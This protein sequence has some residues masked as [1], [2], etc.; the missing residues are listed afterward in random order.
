MVLYG[1]KIKTKDFSE[2]VAVYDIK[3]GKMKSTK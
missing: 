1:E 2:T 3:L